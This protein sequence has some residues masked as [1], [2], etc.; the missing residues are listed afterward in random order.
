MRLEQAVLG[1]GAGRDEADDGALEGALAGARLGVLHLF[2]DGDAEAAADEAGEVGLGGVD[3]DAAH[4]NGLAPVLAAAGEGDVEGG[5]G[6]FGVLEEQLVE[7]PH[8]EEEQG[9]GVFGLE[10][11][12]LRHGGGGALGA[13][14]GAS[15]GGIGGSVA[16]GALR[17]PWSALRPGGRR[18]PTPGPSL[19]QV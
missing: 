14:G 5:G 4:G 11:E 19:T 15:S 7:V 6:G 3:G 16:A 1:K 12:P 9:V 2:G 13:G 17:W 8:S 10:G 18:E